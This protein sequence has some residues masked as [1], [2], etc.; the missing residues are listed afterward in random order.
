MN[1]S[2]AATPYW[3][4]WVSEELFHDVDAQAARYQGYGQEYQQLSRGPFE[5]RFRT[6]DFGADLVIHF[7][8]AN[9]EI[10]A[11][12][13]TPPG[14]YGA[15]FLGGSSPPC[16]LNATEF[17]QDHLVLSPENRTVEGKTA[18]GVSIYCMDVSRSLFPEEGTG[19][20]RNGVLSDPTRLTA[21]RELVQ[22]GLSSFLRLGSLSDYSAAVC[23]FKSSLAG[24]LSQVATD[25]PAG[26][27]PSRR[28]T[29]HRSVRLYRRAREF[30]EHHLAEGVSIAALCQHA[31]ASRR[32]LESVF[33][34]VIGLSPGGYIRVL[35]LNLIRRDLTAEAG[36]DVSIGV[37]AARHGIW[38]WSRF[39]SQYRLLFG[40]LP[41]ETRM[42]CRREV[43]ADT[44]V[45]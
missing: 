31:G 9:R 30:I 42:R 29:A 38:H 26:S 33:R 27:A 45:R 18:A 20:L 35:Q 2:T 6:F 25:N 32:S 4:S 8:T 7:E 10:A 44:T 14:R 41:S 24:I 1:D 23:G 17:S 13:S 36:D 28:Y 19:I 37:I 22:T 34:S 15:C 11:S 21:L 40:E 43:G 3:P 16:A 12:A 39:S 5:G